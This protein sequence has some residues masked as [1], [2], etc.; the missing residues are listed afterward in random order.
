MGLRPHEQRVLDQ[1]ERALRACDPKLAGMLSM[2]TRL[3]AYERVPSE[4]RPLAVPTVQ[5]AMANRAAACLPR[6]MTLQSGMSAPNSR[7]LKIR[8][9]LAII[10]LLVASLFALVTVGGSHQT[11]PAACSMAWSGAVCPATFSPKPAPTAVGAASGIS[12]EVPRP[13]PGHPR[14][15]VRPAPRRRGPHLRIVA[16]QPVARGTTSQQLVKQRWSRSHQKP[17]G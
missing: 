15:P 14:E 13:L 12:S 2:F 1:I 11:S 10:T 9:V 8:I 17:Q 7:P 6:L 5:N 16:R 3:E 4:R